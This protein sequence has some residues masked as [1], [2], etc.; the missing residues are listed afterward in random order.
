MGRREEEKV[1]TT[2]NKNGT[3]VGRRGLPV[4]MPAAEAAGGREE[5]I[6]AAPT[7]TTDAF[8]LAHARIEAR[9]LAARAKLAPPKL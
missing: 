3:A 6:Q 4:E 7:A 8:L 1:E 9:C 5:K 2:N